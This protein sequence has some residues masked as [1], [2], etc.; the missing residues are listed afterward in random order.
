MDV[1][2]AWLNPLFS[3]ISH[4]RPWR[5]RLQRAHCIPAA[6]PAGSPSRTVY[7]CHLGRWLGGW[8]FF[9]SAAFFFV[10]QSLS[11]FQALSCFALGAAGRAQY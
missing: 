4:H 10:T 9:A 1:E 6:V 2:G 8:R 7:P 5:R 3:Q 11:P